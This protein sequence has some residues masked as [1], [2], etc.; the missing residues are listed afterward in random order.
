MRNAPRQEQLVDAARQAYAR[1]AAI[2]RRLKHTNTDVRA[3]LTGYGQRHPDVRK[4]RVRAVLLALPNFG[5]EVVDAV[6]RECGVDGRK[7]FASL[8][9]KEGERIANRI[10][11]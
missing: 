11:V 4:M 10:D 9:V 6:L 3:L 1:R 2:R 8:S 7:S 5:E